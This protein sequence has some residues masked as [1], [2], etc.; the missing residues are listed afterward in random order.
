[1]YKLIALDMDGTLLNSSHK[2]SA[3]NRNALQIL[4]ERGIHVVLAS[5][6]PLQGLQPHLQTLGL[7]Y[8]HHYVV[9]F[10]GCLVQRVGNGEVLHQS[11]ISGQQVLAIF[12]EA[13]K[14]GVYCH[15]FTNRQQLITHQDNRF[16]RIEAEVNQVE[17][18]EYDFNQIRP[19]Q[20]F[21]KMMMVADKPLLDRV[22]ANLPDSLREAFTVVRSYPYFFEFLNPNSNKGVAVA[23]LAR[24]LGIAASEVICA[25][26]AGNDLHMLE[27]AGLAVAMQNASPEIKAVADVIAPS[28]DADGI[29]EIIE[30][31]FA[32]LFADS[33]EM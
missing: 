30:Q 19:E 3:R 16:T 24:Q 17:I 27:Y 10:N 20:R 6:R 22:E 5:G 21:I 29:A 33:M 23:K 25:G 14:Q 1:M 18:L 31:Q 12:E 13:Q 32:C 26:D 28:N 8:D 9:S 11:T 2:I 4:I 7:T 15:A